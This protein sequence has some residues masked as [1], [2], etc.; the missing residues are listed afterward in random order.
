MRSADFVTL[1][2]HFG[3]R[4]DAPGRLVDKLVEG[5]RNPLLLET[6]WLERLQDLGLG[7]ALEFRFMTRTELGMDPANP[8]R[9]T[10]GLLHIQA[11][12]IRLRVHGP[13]HEETI[14]KSVYCPGIVIDGRRVIGLPIGHESERL[15]REEA[16]YIPVEPLH[17]PV[18]EDLLRTR[19]VTTMATAAYR[20]DGSRTESPGD[21]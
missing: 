3:V 7:A 11:G 6:S 13:G 18:V 21:L 8:L 4:P 1:Y 5:S 12:V 16:P 15:L 19:D 10:S 17:Q 9:S 14:E 2:D 20:G